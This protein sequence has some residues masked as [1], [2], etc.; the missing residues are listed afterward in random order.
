MMEIIIPSV[1]SLVVL[2]FSAFKNVKDKKNKKIAV[3]ITI[4]GLILFFATMYFNNLGKKQKLKLQSN[5][6]ALGEE[7][8]SLNKE[9]LGNR[10]VIKE[11]KEKIIDLEEKLDS[12][13]SVVDSIIMQN[14]ISN[15]P[16]LEKYI[17]INA[18]ESIYLNGLLKK[19]MKIIV[20]QSNCTQNVVL[21]HNDTP[22]SICNSESCNIYIDK[23]GFEN[24]SFLVNQGRSP[25][26]MMISVYMSPD[27]L[28]WGD[29][30]EFDKV[31]ADPIVN[32]RSKEIY[33][34]FND[35]E[36]EGKW[37]LTKFTQHCT[38]RNDWNEKLTT[39]FKINRFYEDVDKGFCLEGFKYGE[40][41]EKD[42]I[43][44]GED[45]QI[46]LTNGKLEDCKLK[47]PLPN[48]SGYYL[49]HDV[50]YLET[51]IKLHGTFYSGIYGCNGSLELTRISN[52]HEAK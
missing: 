8:S 49:F 9:L 47:I 36:T 16:I 33:C 35:L 29:D 42:Y 32:P 11:S 23:N 39:F 50:T 18:Q 13:K 31:F 17:Q 12:A 34:S 48:D 25:C 21:M 30:L 6:I 22:Y 19:G 20:S 4:A 3:V 10:K 27:E 40:D 44:Y 41:Y 45:T 1:L 37:E 7:L 38:E 2:I 46:V 14:K 52:E 5:I 43:I 51:R 26:G 15:N 24:S 28:K